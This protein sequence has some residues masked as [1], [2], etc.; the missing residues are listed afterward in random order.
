M[1][2]IETRGLIKRFGTRNVLDG[3]DFS[4]PAGSVTGLLGANGAGKTTTLKAI[5][6]FLPPEGGRVTRGSITIG[7]KDMLRLA[8]HQIVRR[9]VFH[10]REGRHIFGDMTVEE[11]LIAATFAQRR[12]RSRK[13]AFG[14][15]YTYF[16]ILSTRRDQQAGYLSGGEQQMLAIGRALVA[17]PEM[18]LLDE[19]SLGLAPLI[20]NEIF[21]I[22]ARINRE[23]G[24]SILLVEQNATIALKYASYGYVM[25]NGRTVLS[26]T[27]AELAANQDIQK[28]YLGVDTD[29]AA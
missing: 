9:G 25:E 5:S 24:V 29:Q 18:I 26:G 19:P 23:K 12:A 15:V 22:I 21:E 16:P 10:V 2:P 6:S 7:G 4:V 27:T 11:N 14:E 17:D 1:I 3:C 8:P 13:D 20:V 28:Y